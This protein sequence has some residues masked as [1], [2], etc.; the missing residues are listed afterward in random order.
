MFQDVHVMIFI[1]FGFLMVFLRHHAWTSVSF[2]FLVSAF[3]IQLGILCEGFWVNMFEHT[4]SWKKIEL[5]VTS[6]IGGDFAAGAVLISFGAVLGKVNSFQLLVM[7]SIETV[8]YTFN[9]VL[10]YVEIET[11]D[12]GGSIFIHTF[13]AYFGLAVSATLTRKPAKQNPNNEA[14]NVSNLVA[15]VGTLFLWMYWPSFNG[16]LATGNA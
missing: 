3:V 4:S 5:S 11:A 16:I 14:S 1:G 12:I 9:V 6:L 13:G 15:M 10:G 2:N 7:A 8:F